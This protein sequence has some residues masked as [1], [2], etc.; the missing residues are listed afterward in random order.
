MAISTT[1]DPVTSSTSGA[2]TTSTTTTTLTTTTTSAPPAVSINAGFTPLEGAAVVGVSPGVQVS[3]QGQVTVSGC[4]SGIVERRSLAVA[5]QIGSQDIPHP[6]QMSL[7][8]G[9]TGGGTW[10]WSYVGLTPVGGPLAIIVTADLGYAHDSYF[11]T[12]IRKVV[13]EYDTVS[14]SKAHQVIVATAPV[15]SVPTDGQVFPTDPGSTTSTIRAQG[16]VMPPPPAPAQV[17]WNLDPTAAGVAATGTITTDALGNWTASIPVPLGLHTLSFNAG[18]SVAVFV[19]VQVA[20]ATDIV[21]VQ[22]QS[23]LQGLVEFGTQPFNRNG[24]PRVVTP[25]SLT[26]TLIDSKFYQSLTSLLDGKNSVK[27]NEIVRR[28]RICVEVL[29]KYLAVNPSTAAQQQALKTAEAAYRQAAYLSLLIQAGTSYD[30]IRLARTYSRTTANDRAKLQAIADRLGIDLSQSANDELNQLYFDLTKKPGDVGALKE[31]D[32]ERLFGLV[33][34]TRDPFSQGLVVRDDRLQIKRWMLQGVDYNVTNSDGTISVSIIN[35]QVTLKVG[36]ATLATGRIE[37]GGKVVL[38]PAANSKVSGWMEITYLADTSTIGLCVVPLLL[39]WQQQRLR[40][41]WAQVDFETTK[42]PVFGDSLQQIVSWNLPGLDLLHGTDANGFL[43]LSLQQ[44]A[45]PKFTVNVYKDKARTMLAATGSANSPAGIVNLNV[46]NTTNSYGTITINYQADTS[47]IALAIQT[48]FP[49]IIDPDLL[50]DRDFKLPT[51]KT[52]YS[53]YTSRK[54]QVA[55]WFSQL[56]TQRETAASPQAGLN[57]ILSTVLRDPQYYPNGMQIADI[58]ALDGQRQQGTDISPQL[59]ALSLAVDAFNYLVRVCPF[60]TPTTSLLD[61]EWNDIYSVLVQVQKRRAFFSWSVGEQQAG[62]TLGPDFFNNPPALPVAFATG[63]DVNGSPLPDGTPDPHWTIIS[64]PGGTSGSA[65]VT[66]SNTGSPVGAPWIPNTSTSH[67][68]SPR[69]DQSQGDAPGLYTYRTTIDL[70]G[71]DP[72][73][74]RLNLKVAVDDHLQAVLVNNQI[75]GI[76]AGGFAAFKTLEISGPFQAGMNTLDFVVLNEGSVTNRTGIRVEID[77]ANV[78]VP[79]ALPLWRATLEARTKW[80]ARLQGRIDQEITLAEASHADVDATE[81]DTLPILKDALAAAC[82]TRTSIPSLYSSGAQGSSV[83]PNWKIISINNVPP[84]ANTAF[85]TTPNPAWLANSTKS[86]WISPSA[87]EVWATDA[88]GNY[89]YRTVFDLTGFD[90][91]SAQIGISLAADNS[92]TDVILNGTSLQI[93]AGSFTAFT[94]ATINRAFVPGVNILDVILNNLGASGNPSGLRVEFSSSSAATPVTAEWLSTRLLIDVQGNSLQKTTRLNHATE[95][96]QELFF[97]LRNHAFEQ[98]LPQPD[99]ASWTIAEELAL[100]DREWSWTGSFAK[101]QAMM[102]VFLYPE[103]LLLPTLR[104]DALNGEPQ[105]PWEMSPAFSHLVDRLDSHSPLTPDV[106]LSEANNYSAE[107]NQ[108]GNLLYPDL[109]QELKLAA[110][111]QDPRTVD[112]ARLA[113]Q[114]APVLKAYSDASNWIAVGLLWEAWYFVP[115]HIALELQ[116]AAQYEAALDWYRLVYAYELPLTGSGSDLQRR[117]FPGLGVESTQSRYLQIPSWIVDASNPHQVAL[118]RACPYTRFTILSIIQCLLDFGDAQFGLETGESLSNARLLYL[119]AVELLE[120]VPDVLPSD[121]ISES[122]PR[123]ATMRLHAENSLFKLRSGRNLAGMVRVTQEPTSESSVSI[124]PTAYRYSV[125]IDRARQLA[126]MAQQIESSYLAALQRGDEEAY[127]ALRASQDLE[128]AKA[129]VKLE[130]LKVQ[131]AMD[132]VTLAQEQTVRA[133]IQAHHYNDLLNSDI[134]AL[135]QTSID[136]LYTEAGLQ[137]AAGVL[138]GIAAW[139]NGFSFEG[140]FKSG[141]NATESAAQ[142]VSSAAAAVGAT[143]SA[144]SAQASVEEKKKDWQFQLAL[145]SQDVAIGQQ[146]VVLAGDNQAIAFQDLQNATTQTRHAQATADFLA[147]KFTNADLY[148]WMSGVLGGVYAYFLRQATT[149]ARL[150]EYQLAFE[151]Q[152]KPLSV[153]RADYWQPASSATSASGASPQAPDRRGL[154]GAERLQRDLAQLDQYAFDTDKRKLQITRMISL[155]QLDPFAFQRFRQTGVMRFA[156]PMALFDHDFPGQ[157]LRLLK[158]V[159][160]SVIALIPPIQ[161]IRATLANPG[162]SR[163]VVQ[164]PNSGFQ[165]V[166]VC[167]DPQLIALSSPANSTGLFDLTDTQSGL[168]LP[169]EGLGVDTSWEF[170]MAPAVN[171]VDFSTIADVLLTVDYTALDSPDYRQ[172]VLQGLSQ[173]IQADRAF[174]FRQDFAD[175]WYDLNNSG[176]SATPMRVQFETGRTDFPPNIQDDSLT[177]A[178]LLLYFVPAPGASFTGQA[179]LTLSGADIAGNSATVTGVASTPNQV[180]STRRGNAAN[181]RPMIGLSP[182]GKWTLDLS[183]PDMSGLF[184]G[185]KIQDILFVVTYQGHLPAWPT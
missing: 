89:T 94:S 174:S 49:P 85:V 29:R 172:E 84:A 53:V 67:W 25:A 184:N 38:S 6:A 81:E 55:S 130:T 106:A 86:K 167:R 152:E 45:G 15:V 115:L 59:T 10:N 42:G 137:A 47:Q 149:V 93:T 13:W 36:T 107:L 155:A 159:R 120:Q 51:L 169:F 2:T 131:E 162:I 44:T 39:R 134:L 79:A 182:A 104:L 91:S 75:S 62:F 136:L 66:M 16:K 157:Y 132:S 96:M 122:N 99:V 175:A 154:T 33:D 37:A 145:S 43:Y 14:D 168:L 24:T 133:Q 74:V 48:S 178:Q 30:E 109:P 114:R 31:S 82:C 35:P 110:A 135:E 164:D 87:A 70:S 124:Q 20:L 52:A 61:S 100:F 95:M 68:I 179:K 165:S 118:T 183:D 180:I 78:P 64:T 151:R 71:Y 54:T 108:K 88:P 148:R 80:Q 1:Q 111:Y 146:Q 121:F 98:L 117:I 40:R 72:A 166:T 76:K 173:S 101:W 139:Q 181:W 105:A 77:F 141:A 156:T 103:N 142:V 90:P 60:V 26:Q 119:N 144:L 83:D 57:A 21:D 4:V 28:A 126:G 160:V 65:Y 128:S 23:Y 5:V 177:I 18:P 56:K 153:I 12:E 9:T 158:R 63:V 129:V 123:L 112:L 170:V 147:Q 32:L 19:N 69:A 8:S 7:V 143:A 73:S 176:Q 161:G 3:V 27:S 41:Q 138:Y 116:N 185:H 58:V 11:D 125:L 102:L 97:A 46:A 113:A 34:T 150:A 127:T 92:V 22:P 163:V 140:L 17:T 171:P 50:M